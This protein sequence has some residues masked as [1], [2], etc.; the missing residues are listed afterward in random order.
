MHIKRLNEM[1]KIEWGLIENID[2]SRDYGIIEWISE[3]SSQSKSEEIKKYTGLCG[4]TDGE[5]DNDEFLKEK[6]LKQAEIFSKIPEEIRKKEEEI[7]LLDKDKKEKYW[8]A[9][10]EVLYQFQEDLIHNDFD[11][12]VELFLDEDDDE[13]IDEILPEIKEKYKDIIEAKMESRKFN[14]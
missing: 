1:N 8:Y 3:I 7:E 4:I 9:A 5:M 2:A 11:L 13:T 14:F 12:L 6:K 10:Y